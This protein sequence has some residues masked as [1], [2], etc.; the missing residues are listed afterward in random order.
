MPKQGQ[1]LQEVGISFIVKEKISVNN[2]KKF[3]VKLV[4]VLEVEQVN[5]FVNLLKPGF[6]ISVSIKESILYFG[7]WGQE[8]YVRL[9]CASCKQFDEIKVVKLIKSFF[10]ERIGS[11]RVTIISDTTI[12]DEVE[13]LC[14]NRY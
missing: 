12:K 1:Y 6:D 7:F 3:L 2:A 8:K 10:K 11:V 5:L 13:D 4:D 14:Q 9:Y